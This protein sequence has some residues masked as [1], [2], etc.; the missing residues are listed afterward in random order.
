VQT[1]GSCVCPWS[2][3]LKPQLLVPI[4]YPRV[5]LRSPDLASHPL[6]TSPWSQG[7]SL[8]PSPLS[9]ALIPGFAFGL[10]PLIV[11]TWSH[12]LHPSVDR[13][14]SRVIVFQLLVTVP[15]FPAVVLM[16]YVGPHLWSRL[17]TRLQSLPSDLGPEPL[18]PSPWSP[19][20][21]QLSLSSWVLSLPFSVTCPQSLIP[22][23]QWPVPGLQSLVPRPWSPVL[24]LQSLFPSP[25]SLV[26]HLQSLV[27]S[28]H[29]C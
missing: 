13:A 21:W 29:S 23:P 20:Q 3:V 28:P 24:H 18:F 9:P 8:M 17:S 6:V 16:S 10:Q 4:F 26:L 1:I 12:A 5:C 15:C 19:S 25:R 27:P 7:L 2:P 22:S 11:C 14:L